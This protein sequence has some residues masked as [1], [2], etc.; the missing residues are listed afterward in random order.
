MTDK[1]DRKLFFRELGRYSAL[2]LE[3]AASVL[4]GL[5]IGY[6]LDKWLGT[7][8]W[9]MVLWIGIGFAA[10]VRSLYRAA[11]RSGKE[12]EENGKNRGEPRD[13]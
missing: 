13:R 8:P 9:L 6:Y 12:L 2:G 11:L 7:G 5:A 3:M 4:I 1:Q 10:G